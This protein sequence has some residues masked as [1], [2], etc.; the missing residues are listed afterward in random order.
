MVDVDIP[1]YVVNKKLGKRL[2]LP[3]MQYLNEKVKVNCGY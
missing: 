2:K 3:L 1:C